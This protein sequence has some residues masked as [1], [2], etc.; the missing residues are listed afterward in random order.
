VA[1]E[2]QKTENVD[3]KKLLTAEARCAQIVKELL[4]I[5]KSHI[6]MVFIIITMH[7]LFTAPS[8]LKCH[9]LDSSELIFGRC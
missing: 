3:L 8:Y 9:P 5:E 6:R 4:S 2:C 7:I 1:K